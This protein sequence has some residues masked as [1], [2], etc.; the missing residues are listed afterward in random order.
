MITLNHVGR[1]NKLAD[2]GRVLEEGGDFTPVPP[3]RLNDKRIFRS[4]YLFEVIK[5]GKS[6]FLT[7]G[8]VNRFEVHE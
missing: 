5:C 2:F 1:V 6:R 8:F 3:P 7:G 4:P